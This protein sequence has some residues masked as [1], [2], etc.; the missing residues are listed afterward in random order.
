MRSR[1]IMMWQPDIT[2][3]GSFPSNMVPKITKHTMVRRTVN[4]GVG[5]C[6]ILVQ[7]AVAIKNR[8]EHYFHG[9]TLL[10]DFCFPHLSRQLL[11]SRLVLQLGVEIAHQ[12]FIPY[13]YLCYQITI[14]VHHSQLL[15]TNLNSLLYL[16]PAEVFRS[17]KYEINMLIKNRMLLLRKTTLPQFHIT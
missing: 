6:K 3:M 13:H 2:K 4:S 12:S 5:Q 17:H 7:H 14:A 11:G 16:F 10:S 15:H 8:R 1:V 9:R